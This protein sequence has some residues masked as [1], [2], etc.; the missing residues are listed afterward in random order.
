MFK[1]KIVL[2]DQIEQFNGRCSLKKKVENALFPR[3]QIINEVCKQTKAE[4]VGRRE[5]EREREANENERENEMK[6]RTKKTN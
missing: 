3:E 4:R 5:R 1:I 6:K 2:D